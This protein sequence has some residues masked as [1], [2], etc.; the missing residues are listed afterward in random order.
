MF[1]RI[2]LSADNLGLTLTPFS[3]VCVVG[4][5]GQG[6][7]LLPRETTIERMTAVPAVHSSIGILWASDKTEATNLLSSVSLHIN[8]C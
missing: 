6:T 1:N 4:M 5:V 2:K 3:T 8:C 7:L